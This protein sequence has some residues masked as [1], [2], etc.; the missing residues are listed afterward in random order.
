MRLPYWLLKLL[1]LF[2]YICPKCKREVKQ[3]SHKCPYCG[4]NYGVPLRVPP[5]C[6]QS[7]EELERYVHEKIFPKVSAW[8]RE[9]LAQYFTTIFSDGFESGDFSAWTSIDLSGGTAT[10]QN[11]IK[12]HG[13]YAGKWELGTSTSAWV[14]VKKVF[15]ASYSTTYMRIYYYFSNSIPDANALVWILRS[16]KAGVAWVSGVYIK[17]VSGELRW[18]VMNIAGGVSY[19][20][21]TRV[22]LNTWYCVELKT[23]VSTSAGELRLYIDGTEILTQTGLNTGS[24]LIDAIVVG[25]TK[26]NWSTAQ[27]FVGYTDCVVVAD[28]YIG[29]EIPKPKGSIVIHAKLAGVI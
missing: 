12:H 15:A 17:N 13:T 24:D 6:L 18:G 7:K 19:D 2:D 21:T 25:S 4:E 11:I 16:Q 23:V 10:V 20:S 26:E 8:Q 28:T 14:D 27:G 22:A 29:P 9:Y 3:E 1:P 5:K